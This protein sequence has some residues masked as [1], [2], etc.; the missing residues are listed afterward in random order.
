MFPTPGG[1]AYEALTLISQH[2]SQIASR[3]WHKPFGLLIDSTCYNGQNELPDEI[4]KKLELL[5]PT[6]L[7]QHLTRVYVYNMNSTFR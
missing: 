2:V 3:L 4:F 6:E 5:S 7:S 1:S